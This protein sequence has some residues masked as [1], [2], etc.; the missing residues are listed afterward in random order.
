MTFVTDARPHDEGHLCSILFSV[1][2]CLSL[3][4]KHRFL[5]R[6]DFSSPPYQYD[7][8]LTGVRRACQPPQ[9]PQPSSSL[10]P[11]LPSSSSR[12]AGGRAAPVGPAVGQLAGQGRARAATRAGQARP[13]QARPAARPP[14]AACGPSVERLAGRLGP[15]RQVKWALC[16]SSTVGTARSS[17]AVQFARPPAL[18]HRP[19]LEWIPRST[20]RP[21]LC[22]N[23]AE[24]KNWTT[25]TCSTI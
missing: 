1:C 15:R 10:L 7:G 19:A 23:V 2:V 20:A 4:T 8:A 25:V 17:P 21:S 13:G 11:P 6:R 14:S 3:C 22:A 12:C 24:I 18:L 16:K 5:E 9:S